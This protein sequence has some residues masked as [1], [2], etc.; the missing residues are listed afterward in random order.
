MTVRVLIIISILLGLLPALAE[1]PFRY[2]SDEAARAVFFAGI[3][4]V[5]AVWGFRHPQWR[6][7]PYVFILLL[8]PLCNPSA[9]LLVMLAVVFSICTISYLAGRFVAWG[10]RQGRIAY[11]RGHL[12]CALTSI[13]GWVILS[14]FLWL[15][16]VL[17]GTPLNFFPSENKAWH[18]FF[19]EVIVVSAVWGFRHPWRRI[20]V[21]FV[22]I[23]APL[24]L[25]VINPTLCL[26]ITPWFFSSLLLSSV[27]SYAFG[28]LIAWGW[29][30]I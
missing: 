13:F 6:K 5:S 9:F 7:M 19:C 25:I 17:A 10:W 30:R 12:G 28:K 21:I 1:T 16:L 8:A 27:I 24:C 18:L 14:C 11:K 26:Q 29:R 2:F 3:A 15:P 22:W 23:F 4:V 20:S